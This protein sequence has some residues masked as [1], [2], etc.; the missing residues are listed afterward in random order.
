MRRAAATAGAVLLLGIA[1]TAEAHLRVT[2]PTTRY[3]DE[4]KTG[5]CGRANGV[6]SANVHTFAPGAQIRIVWEEFIDHPGHY[7]IAFDDD[8][9]DDFADPATADDLYNNDTVL[10]DGIADMNGGVYNHMVTLPNIECDNC[11]LQVIQVMTDKPPFGDGNDMYYQ[12]IDL[13]LS[14]DAP[15]AP[16]AGTVP[17]GPDA[18]DDN[19]ANPPEVSGGCSVT[20]SE[21]QGQ[22][23]M[24]L[25]LAACAIAAGITRRRRRAELPFRRD[26]R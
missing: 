26:R 15:G 9:D 3:G 8:G 25:V 24:L 12:C 10:E 6:R 4:Q 14:N 17:M 1:T 20:L 23:G 21:E 18:G 22:A 16:D 7:R 13:V 19:P 5:P 11:T 2:E